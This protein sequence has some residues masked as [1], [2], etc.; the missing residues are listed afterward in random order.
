MSFFTQFGSS[1]Q[2]LLQFMVKQSRVFTVPAT[3][4]Y[5][6]YAI[7]G[8]GS[9]GCTTVNGLYG[10]STGG[11]AGGLA[12]KS[13]YLTAGDSL[14]IT[15]GAGGA[16]AS[17]GTQNVAG[18]GTAGGATT[19][20]G[21]GV[22]LTASGGGGGSGVISANVYNLSG[23]QGGNA[24]GGDFNFQGGNG[25]SI[26]VSTATHY[27]NFYTGGGAVAFYGGRFNGGNITKNQAN[28]TYAGIVYMTGGAGV[29][30]NGGDIVSNVADNQ[31]S[32][33]YVGGGAGGSPATYTQNTD[34]GYVGVLADAGPS[35]PGTGS[36]GNSANVFLPGAAGTGSTTNTYGPNVGFGGGAGSSPN[37]NQNM[38]MIGLG[39][40]GSN[41]GANHKIFPDLGGGAGA[42]VGGTAVGAPGGGGVVFIAR[43]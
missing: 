19:V 12:I 28:G 22:S 9:G 27:T 33:T 31:F 21:P 36:D 23:G 38:T 43:S 29:G 41:L 10:K 37:T 25:G 26:T 11:G 16:A 24:T 18:N 6:I 30:G 4:N 5:L 13:V 40:G 34:N 42:C 8:G 39:G 20:V 1:A 3:G 15:I 14:S 7:G 32:V 17:T 2:P 35:L